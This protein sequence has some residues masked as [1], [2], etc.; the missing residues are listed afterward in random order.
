MTKS[1]APEV[2]VPDA[3]PAFQGNY[4]LER[5]EVEGK[6]VDV[7]AALGGIWSAWL[8]GFE[9]AKVTVTQAT[10]GFKENKTSGDWEYTLCAVS[11]ELH[12]GQWRDGRL[13]YPAGSAWGNAGFVRK[14]GAKHPPATK[15]RVKKCTLAIPATEL[16]LVSK[17]D[18]EL[19]LISRQGAKKQTIHLVRTSPEMPDFSELTD[20][21]W[22]KHH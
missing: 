6:S 19:V 5:V 18:S 1:E 4:R 9:N 21:H 3:T 17:T 22:L 8:F 10:I 11:L 15:K 14:V 12:G 20:A 16:Q 7:S 2:A 13:S